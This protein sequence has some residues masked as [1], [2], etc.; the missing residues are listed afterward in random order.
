MN[1][2]EAKG[3]KKS[4]QISKEKKIE[5][6]KG[7]DIVMKE[8]EFIALKGASGSGKST[9]IH[10]LATLD[11]ADSG[12]IYFDG[13]KLNYKEQSDEELSKFRNQDIGIIYQFHH[14]LPEFTS[15][16]NV[17]MPSLIAG[18]KFELAKDEAMSLLEDTGMADR[19]GHFPNELSGGEQQRIAI[20]RALIN[21]PKLIYADEP[22]GSLD[23][24]NSENII[25][26][27]SELKKKYN[28]T[29]LMATHSEDIAGFASRVMILE[30]GLVRK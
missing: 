24:T 21:K 6:L 19:I 2:L 29:V 3:I 1:I 27:L 11:L 25:N 26:M 23:K 13:N 18:N 15:L 12:E 16:E 8:G 5:V 17:M 22:T 14:L 7:V 20:S 10:I 30:N 9:L 4:F 28:L